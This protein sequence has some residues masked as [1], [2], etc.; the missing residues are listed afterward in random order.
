[1]LMHVSGV[2]LISHWI[3]KNVDLLQ[4]RLLVDVSSM[5]HEDVLMYPQSLLSLPDMSVELTRQY[6]MFEFSKQ[7][8]INY[9]QYLGMRYNFSELGCN[10]G[11]QTIFNNAFSSSKI[12]VRKHYLTKNFTCYTKYLLIL[13][14]DKISL[15]TT[16][17]IGQCFSLLLLT[18]S[19]R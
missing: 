9:T 15:H 8:Q 18:V 2:A 11:S 10:A 12:I 13:I 14:L 17:I 3:L 5:T 6:S 1:M 4:L 19:K 16:A 7:Q